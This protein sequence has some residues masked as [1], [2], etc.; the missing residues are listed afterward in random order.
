MA[1]ALTGAGAIVGANLSTTN[2]AHGEVTAGQERRTFESGGQQSVPI[3]REIA[4]T[5]RQM[6]GRLARLETAAQKMQMNAARSAAVE[7]AAEAN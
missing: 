6:D 1:V 7:P 4:A 2:V 5:L 3:L